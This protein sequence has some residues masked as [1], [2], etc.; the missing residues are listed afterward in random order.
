[1][2]ATEDE[3]TDA[4]DVVRLVGRAADGDER[5]WERLVEEYER[6]I[7]AITGQ[8]KLGGS[9]AADVAQTT[10]LRLLEHIGRLEQPGR[11]G[12][13]L[14]VT[15]RHECLRHLAARKKAVLASD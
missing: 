13:W 2:A 5:A 7:W 14:A 15:A 12:S 8:F 11:V 6:L 3:T 4:L 1:M 10:W 9:D